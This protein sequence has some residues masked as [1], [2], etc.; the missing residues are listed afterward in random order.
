MDTV[1]PGTNS[2]PAMNYFPPRDADHRNRNARQQGSK[3][4]IISRSDTYRRISVALPQG[5]PRFAVSSSA[6]SLVSQTRKSCLFHV[7]SMFYSFQACSA[8][9]RL[10]ARSGKRSDIHSNENIVSRYRSPQSGNIKTH[11]L[12]VGRVFEI[13][14]QA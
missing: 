1:G 11:T 14:V 9:I 3:A 10:M 6:V 4:A 8:P 7:E 2:N 12:P 5:S 13:L